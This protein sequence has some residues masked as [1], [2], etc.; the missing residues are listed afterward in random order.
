VI[1]FLLKHILIFWRLVHDVMTSWML[2]NVV[3][4]CDLAVF[5]SRFVTASTYFS[6]QI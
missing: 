1:K 5:L 3:D 6:F 4:I 2:S